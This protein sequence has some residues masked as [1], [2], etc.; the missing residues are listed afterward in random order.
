[1]HLTEGHILTTP[2]LP[3]VVL[4]SGPAVGF[5]EIERLERHTEL[6]SSPV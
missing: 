3:A 2:K 5:G 6:L 4:L 1:M